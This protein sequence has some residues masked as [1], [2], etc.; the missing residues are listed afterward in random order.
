[1]VMPISL[2]FITA[3]LL[4]FNCKRMKKHFKNSDLS[5]QFIFRFNFNNHMTAWQVQQQFFEV[6]KKYLFVQ[7]MITLIFLHANSCNGH[8]S[9][10]QVKQIC[11][12]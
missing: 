9:E 2:S 5:V 10:Q 3:S 8:C 11:K 12:I 6:W 7:L 4:F 1:M